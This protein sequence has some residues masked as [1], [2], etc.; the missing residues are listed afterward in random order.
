MPKQPALYEGMYIVDSAL[1]D[2]AVQTIVQTLEEHVRSLGG[3]VVAT[4]EFGR[5]RLAYEIDGHT[6]GTYMILYF[7]GFGDVVEE[8]RHEM[9]L[10]EGIV[11]GIVVVPNPKAI[12]EPQAPAETPAP[13]EAAAA[14]EPDMA[15]AEATTE[16]VAVGEAVAEPEGE[17]AAEA[18]AA[19]EAEAEPAEETEAA[20]EAGETAEAVESAEDEA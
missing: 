18:E 3:E 19:E 2:S 6:T 12:F 7:K 16:E 13:E 11:R 5:R 15:L 10:I 9:H 17:A 4:R 8:V 20:P 14:A 1:E